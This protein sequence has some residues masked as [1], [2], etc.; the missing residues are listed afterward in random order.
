MRMTIS[1]HGQGNTNNAAEFSQMTHQ[2]QVNG[3][4]TFPHNLWKS[5]CGSNTCTDSSKQWDIITCRLV[6][7]QEVIP[8]VNNLT[9]NVTPG[10]STTLGYVL[11]TYTNLLNTGYN[12]GSHTEPYYRIHAYLVEGSDSARNFQ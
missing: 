4:N 11:Q 10:S 1:G 9:G 8:I 7:G 5:N 3:A 12:G 6:S 2:V